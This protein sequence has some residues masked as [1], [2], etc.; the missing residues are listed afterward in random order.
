MITYLL[1]IQNNYRGLGGFDILDTSEC[2]SLIPKK[3][4]P[5]PSSEILKIDDPYMSHN[6][7]NKKGIYGVS[8]QKRT[9][10]MLAINNGSGIETVKDLGVFRRHKAIIIIFVCVCR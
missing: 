2:H 3:N 7:K 1:G 4:R 9:T 6:S 10:F 8:R 5:T